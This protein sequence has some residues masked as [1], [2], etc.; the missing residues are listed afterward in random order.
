MQINTNN[1]NVIIFVSSAICLNMRDT[2][3]YG[4]T[5][6]YKTKFNYHRRFNQT[7]NTIK[8]LNEE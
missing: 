8:N 2:F 4:N 6:V 5:E 3:I 1:K 7:K